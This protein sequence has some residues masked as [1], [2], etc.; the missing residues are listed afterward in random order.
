MS[1]IWSLRKRRRKRK[2]SDLKHMDE[3]KR[4]QIEFEL[5]MGDLERK[6]KLQG[7]A[8]EKLIRKTAKHCAPALGMTLEEARDWVT[9]Q[10]EKR[11]L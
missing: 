3:A 6:E 2:K 9:S 5:M 7:E 1:D 11:G 8:R 10:F 4:Y